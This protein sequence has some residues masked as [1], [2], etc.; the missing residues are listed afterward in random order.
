MCNLLVS[1]AVAMCNNGRAPA[2]WPSSPWPL[3]SSALD[4]A[5][6]FDLNSRPWALVLCA[7]TSVL[8][9]KYKDGIMIAC[10]TLAAYGSTKR[11]KSFQRIY[12]VNDNCV[13]AAGGEISDFQQIQR[14]LDELTTGERQ[15][16]GNV[17]RHLCR[18]SLACAPA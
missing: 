8:G 4:V 10:D 16:G 11:Y 14:Y 18:T 2:G 7:G 9:I 13:V 6:R 3:L 12:K 1:I 17:S 5:T 15:T